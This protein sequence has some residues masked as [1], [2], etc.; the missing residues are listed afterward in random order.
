[1]QPKTSAQDLY[2]IRLAFHIP[3]RGELQIP[4]FFLK[5]VIVYPPITLAV[6]LPP[7]LVVHAEILH[8]LKQKALHIIWTVKLPHS[9]IIPS[10]HK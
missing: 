10:V 9:L 4:E 2:H 1:M 3:H 6:R 8:K 7:I 5:A